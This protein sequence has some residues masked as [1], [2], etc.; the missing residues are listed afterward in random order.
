MIE[1]FGGKANTSF[2]KIKL[3]FLLVGKDSAPK[4]F[5]ALEEWGL[6]IVTLH[7]LQLL[8]MGQTSFEALENMPAVTSVMFG[9]LRISLL[10]CC[11]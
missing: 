7:R 8:L 1:P 4:K 11:L 10:V 5:K 9:E 3:K 6:V 2:P